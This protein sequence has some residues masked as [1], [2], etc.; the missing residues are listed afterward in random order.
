MR[1]VLLTIFLLSSFSCGS[2]LSQK[3][4]SEVKGRAPGGL[5]KELRTVKA[6]PL[7]YHLA[8][9]FED[10]IKTYYKP[11]G[12]G[13]RSWVTKLMD[14][15]RAALVA[16]PVMDNF[17]N[18]LP[19]R[20]AAVCRAKVGLKDVYKFVS[21]VSG[22]A[23]TFIV[24]HLEYSE[25]GF[26]GLRSYC[27]DHTQLLLETFRLVKLE[28]ASIREISIGRHILNEIRVQKNDTLYRLAFDAGHDRYVIRFYPVN[29]AAIALTTLP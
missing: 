5:S 4:G 28:G 15:S 29:A 20:I 17:N 24:S 7:P 10:R 8:E 26:N 18:K 11:L 13:G 9:P 25:K 16:G 6:V 19:K 2:T 23:H 1:N 12:T 3:S 22:T 14:G 27:R 21:C